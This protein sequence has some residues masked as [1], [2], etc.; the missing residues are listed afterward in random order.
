MQIDCLPEYSPVLDGAV[1][2]VNKLRKSGIKIG[3]TTGFTKV[4]TDVLLREAKK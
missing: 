2:A 1:E 4:M 3:A